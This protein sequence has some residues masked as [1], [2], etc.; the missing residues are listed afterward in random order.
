MI[1]FVRGGILVDTEGYNG[2]NPGSDRVTIQFKN[3]VE[4]T[5]TEEFLRHALGLIEFEKVK[6]TGSKLSPEEHKLLK[7]W[8]EGGINSHQYRIN[9][10]KMLKER[11]HLSLG[12]AVKRIEAE[13][14]GELKEK[15]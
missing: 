4:I 10:I 13:Y 5:L 3:E 1:F 15:R 2:G 11:Q 8:Q 6:K 9:A 7:M 12:E 14:P